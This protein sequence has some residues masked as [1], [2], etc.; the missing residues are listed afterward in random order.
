MRV[1]LVTGAARRIGRHLALSLGAAGYA[2]GVHCNTSLREAAAV[3]EHLDRAAVLP[4][5]LSDWASAER[6]VTDCEAALGPVDLLV[7]C[8]STFDHDDIANLEPETYARN[9]AVNLTAPVNLIRALAVRGRPGSAVNFLD[10]KVW[11]PSPSFL[12]YTL[13]KTALQTATVVLARALAPNLRINAVAPGVVLPSGGQSTDEYGAVVRST[14]L[15]REI[16]LDDIARAVLYLAEAESVTGQT[17]YVDAGFR[18]QD[19]EG[20]EEAMIRE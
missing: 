18:F 16:P 19:Y 17:L 14:L 11:R 8:A 12:S 2:V 6:L 5:D 10:F 9:F 13:A 7:N 4:A 15:G 3:A 20:V 1:A